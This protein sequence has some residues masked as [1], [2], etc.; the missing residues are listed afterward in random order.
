MDAASAALGVAPVRTMADLLEFIVVCTVLTAAG[1]Q[2]Q[3]R[4]ALN[5]QAALPAEVLPLAGDDQAAEDQARWQRN[6]EPAAQ[7]IIGPFRLG[8]TGRP[9]VM[10]ANLRALATV[11]GINTETARAMLRY[12]LTFG[13][14][15]NIPI[16]LAGPRSG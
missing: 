8:D 13:W 14:N 2:G 15:P 11:L 5:P 9:D 16:E 10:R 1:E 4:Y 7:G 12:W 6:H 3:R